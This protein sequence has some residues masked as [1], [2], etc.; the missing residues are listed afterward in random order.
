[1]FKNISKLGT[2][3]KVNELKKVNGGIRFCQYYLFN[4]TETVCQYYNG[5]YFP[6]D[7]R[8]LVGDPQCDAPVPVEL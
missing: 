4:V 8:C 5:H 1:M 3:L 7:S 6:H 2:V